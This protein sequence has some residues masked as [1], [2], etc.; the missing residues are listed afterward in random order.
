MQTRI[1]YTVTV[2]PEYEDWA[3]TASA[4]GLNEF[5]TGNGSEVSI[6]SKVTDTDTGGQEKLNVSGTQTSDYA[7]F[8]H[9]VKQVRVETLITLNGCDSSV[10]MGEFYQ[11][12]AQIPEPASMGMLGAGSIFSLVLRKKNRKRRPGSHEFDSAVLAG[13]DADMDLFEEGSLGYVYTGRERLKHPI[14]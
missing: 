3:I 9:T 11:S 4:L 6:S 10:E 5:V 7:E 1:S 8:C 2:L 14:F 13:D 12:F